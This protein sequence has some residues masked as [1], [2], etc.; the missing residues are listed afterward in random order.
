M[1]GKTGKQTAVDANFGHVTIAKVIN[2]S[3]NRLTC[4]WCLSHALFGVNFSEPENLTSGNQTEKLF[5]LFSLKK[6]YFSN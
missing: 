5:N 2:G 3:F 1:A 4:W 6:Q